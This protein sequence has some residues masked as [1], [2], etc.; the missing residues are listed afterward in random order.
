[1]HRNHLLYIEDILSSIDRIGR[2]VG[3]RTYDKFLKDEMLV[4][5]VVR[6]LEIIGEASKKIP[7]EIK[8]QASYVEWPKIS[9][10][11]NILAHEYFGV[12]PEILWDIIKNKLPDLKDS[13]DKMLGK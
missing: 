11:R 12:D 3:D 1:M 13:M 2:Y 10:F 6:N 5:A 4:D 7:P 8:E 9:G